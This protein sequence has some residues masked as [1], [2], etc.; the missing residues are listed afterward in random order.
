[1]HTGLVEITKTVEQLAKLPNVEQVRAIASSTNSLHEITFEVLPCDI[2]SPE[3]GEL[4]K[5]AVSLAIDTE[6]ELSDKTGNENCL[7]G[8]QLVGVFQNKGRVVAT[9]APILS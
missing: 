1:M 7:F 6:W 9:T 2:D 3:N 5:K 8:V 4:T